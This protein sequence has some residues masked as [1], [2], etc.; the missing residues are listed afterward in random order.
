MIGRGFDL[1]VQLLRALASAEVRARTDRI[2]EQIIGAEQLAPHAIVQEAGV[3]SSASDCSIS[4]NRWNE[5]A[6]GAVEL[7]DE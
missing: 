1:L 3:T 4:S 2:G 7:V 6:A 5:L